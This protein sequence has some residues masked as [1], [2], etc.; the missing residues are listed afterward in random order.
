MQDAAP[1][2]RD[3]V[4]RVRVEIES[5]PLAVLAVAGSAQLDGELERLHEER[6][7]NHVVV[8]EVAPARVGVLVAE[9]PFGREQRRVLGEVLAVHEQV[10]PVHV[11]LHVVEPLG[12]QLV[13][14]VQ[15]HPDVAH[16]DLHCRLRVLVL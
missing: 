9:Q 14:H 3:G 6:G 12:A 2:G 7:P 1:D 8:V 13:D 4:L 5:K 15:G 16:Q 10:L 11:D